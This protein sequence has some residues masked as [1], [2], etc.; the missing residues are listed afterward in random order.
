M[1]A[2]YTTSV[3]ATGGRHGQIRSED[4]L[5]NMKLALPR[6]LAEGGMLRTPKRFSLAATPPASKMR[7]YE[8]AV[9]R[10]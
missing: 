2:L 9:N 1:N 6:E 10:G 7:S 3:T 5:L 8:L 4:G